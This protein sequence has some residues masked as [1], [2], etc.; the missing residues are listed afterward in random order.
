MADPEGVVAAEAGPADGGEQKRPRLEAKLPSLLRK[1]LFDPR[2]TAALREAV[3]NLAMCFHAV[4][5]QV[6]MIHE[7][8][9]PFGVI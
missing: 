8:M 9:P 3:R 5:P 7:N 1:D 6:N 2:Q 4:L